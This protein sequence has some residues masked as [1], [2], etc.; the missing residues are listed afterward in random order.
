MYLPFN[1]ILFIGVK[2]FNLD[3]KRGL[4]EL[5]RFG[6]L[7][8]TNP[9]EIAYFLFHEGRSVENIFVFYEIYHA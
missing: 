7:D 6:F 1:T 4:K 8:A 3:P 9:E 5:D 2:S